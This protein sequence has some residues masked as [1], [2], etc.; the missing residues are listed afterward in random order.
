MPKS[1]TLI[2]PMRAALLLEV[3]PR[4]VTRWADDPA[5]ELTVAEYT[6][7]GQRRYRLTDVERIAAKRN[8]ERA[9]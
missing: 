7:G 8:Q 4:T 6:N 9:A 5:H 3:N 1:D 2:T